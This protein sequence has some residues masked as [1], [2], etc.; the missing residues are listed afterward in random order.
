MHCGVLVG[1]AWETVVLMVVGG[2]VVPGPDAGGDCGDLHAGAPTHPTAMT[3]INR[4]TLDIDADLNGRMVC[5]GP[6][7]VHIRTV[8]ESLLSI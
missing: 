1:A 5:R 4:N 8:L 6:Y 3:A 2:F 7:W